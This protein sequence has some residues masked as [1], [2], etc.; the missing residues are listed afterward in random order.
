MTLEKG[1]TVV[2]YEKGREYSDQ[3]DKEL[4]D[5]KQQV[6]YINCVDV[7]INTISPRTTPFVSDLNETIEDLRI[8]L[9]QM[10]EQD[11]QAEK[12]NL[13]K[14]I[15]YTIDLMFCCKKE[16]YRFPEREIS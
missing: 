9:K 4:R 10:Y 11:L 15:I 8:V 12:P 7:S 2:D 1:V 5:I 3:I 14:K 16:V 6:L 13:M